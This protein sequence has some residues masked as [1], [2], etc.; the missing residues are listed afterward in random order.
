V[1]DEGAKAPRLRR[2][3]RTSVAVSEGSGRWNRKLSTPA[4]REAQRRKIL[5]A[6]T[7]V[8]ATTG[9]A[10]TAV[11]DVL[12][13]SGVGRR[14]FYE[15]F[16]DLRAVVV[17]IHTEAG[18]LA[19]FAVE[20]AAEATTDPVE[21]LRVCVRAFLTLVAINQQLAQVFFVE[22][23]SLGP[24][25][26]MRHELVLQRIATLLLEGVG[27]ALAQGVVTRPPNELTA[28]AL[29]AAIEAVAMRYVRRGEALRAIEAEDT[30]VDLVLSAF[31]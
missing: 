7:Q 10:H 8:I 5:D 24:E 3:K 30:L 2:E 31:R 17:A 1:R 4:R 26:E 25:E 27:Q 16:D 28:F 18:K 23:R 11:Q 20:R 14:A 12:D 13:A 19:L 9:L 29:I 6:A 15:H 22:I 21:R